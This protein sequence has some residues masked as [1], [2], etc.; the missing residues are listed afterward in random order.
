FSHQ[1][2]VGELGDPLHED[3]VRG[4]DVAMREIV[5]MQEIERLGKH[6]SDVKALW[7]RQAGT[8]GAA[9]GVGQGPWPVGGRIVFPTEPFRIAQFH[10]LIEEALGFLE[11]DEL[12]S[13]E[14][15]VLPRDRFVPA[16][17]IKLDVVRAVLLEVR[18]I[19]GLNALPL[20]DRVPSQP[21]FT[22]TAL[23]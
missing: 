10:E 23:A 6:D 11:A 5:Q 3:H 15:G 7:N 13:Q 14:A 20:P 22:E 18:T 19:D 2:D 8:E 21:D 4:L 12:D 16:E 1:A 9:T 17:S